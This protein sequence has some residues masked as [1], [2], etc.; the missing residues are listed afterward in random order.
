MPPTPSPPGVDARDAS[1]ASIIMAAFF[2]LLGVLVMTMVNQRSRRRSFYMV[3][4]QA[5]Q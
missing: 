5:I 4:F 2:N 1:G 3:D